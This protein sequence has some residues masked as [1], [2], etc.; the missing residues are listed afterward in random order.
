MYAGN[1]SATEATHRFIN[2]LFSGNK[3]SFGAAV[4]TVDDGHNNFDVFFVNCIFAGNHATNQLFFKELATITLQ[5]SLIW[6][7]LG[8]QTYTYLTVE[9]CLIDED[10]SFTTP[11]DPLLAPNSNGD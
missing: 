9:N 2:C 1:Y 6:N 3:G 7:N 8:G 5:N 10:P 4:A 11:I